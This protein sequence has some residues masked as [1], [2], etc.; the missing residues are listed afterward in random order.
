MF[1]QQFEGERENMT[2]EE[3]KE[4]YR[5]LQEIMGY[6]SEFDKTLEMPSF[7]KHRKDLEEQMKE[8]I[9]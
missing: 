1:G 3:T 4:C 7:E 2:I 5:N 9:Y 8:G 6:L